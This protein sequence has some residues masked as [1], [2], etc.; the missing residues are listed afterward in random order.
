MK[1]SCKSHLAAYASPVP[2]SSSYDVKGSLVF[3]L[4]LKEH[5]TNILMPNLTCLS[6]NKFFCCN[7]YLK[8][9]RNFFRCHD[10]RM[11]LDSPPTINSTHQ[12]TGRNKSS[13]VAL[14]LLFF[15]FLNDV[16]YNKNF[17]SSRSCYAPC[18]Y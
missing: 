6:I 18:D 9:L 10:D 7:K 4:P 12:Q 13:F 11:V 15:F 1:T 8:K 2:L 17:F 3:L 14:H 16:F 5:F